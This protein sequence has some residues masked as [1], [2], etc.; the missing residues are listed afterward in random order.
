MVE[1]QVFVPCDVTLVRVIVVVG[2]FVRPAWQSCD[3]GTRRTA[4]GCQHAGAGRE[5]ASLETRP[6]DARRGGM[7]GRERACAARPR[8]VLRPALD[9]APAET[10][11]VKHDDFVSR[12]DNGLHHAPV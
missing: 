1:E 3:H 9:F 12:V 5:G 7:G 10:N 8:S 6:Q 4:C 11:L 2:G